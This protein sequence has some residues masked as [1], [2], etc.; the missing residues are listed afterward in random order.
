MY[1]R[2]QACVRREYKMKVRAGRPLYGV[3]IGI[4]MLDTVVPRIPS[5]NLQGVRVFILFASN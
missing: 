1:C 3:P 2:G 4:V 5:C